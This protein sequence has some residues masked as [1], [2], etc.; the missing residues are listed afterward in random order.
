M[1]PANSPAAPT[2]S[3]CRHADAE[4]YAAFIRWRMSRHDSINRL[5]LARKRF[6]EAYP[7]LGNWFTAPLPERVGRLYLTS[8]ASIRG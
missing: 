4:E 8:G 6:V 7:E 3:P 5:L 1:S 2:Q